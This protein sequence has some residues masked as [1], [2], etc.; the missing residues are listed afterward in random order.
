MPKLG[1]RNKK[2]VSSPLES[3]YINTE[4]ESLPA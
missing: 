3:K 4:F 2:A 1:I